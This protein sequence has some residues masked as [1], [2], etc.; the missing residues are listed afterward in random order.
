MAIQDKLDAAWTTS[1]ETSSMFEFRAAAE[2]GYQQ[3]K[4]IVAEIDNIAA[5]GSFVGVDQE[6]KDEGVAIRAIF[7]GAKNSLDTHPDFLNWRQS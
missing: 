7:N 6:I 1:E 5:R 2:K 3:I 4:D